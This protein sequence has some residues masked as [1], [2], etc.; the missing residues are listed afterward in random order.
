[1]CWTK[2]VCMSVCMRVRACVPGRLTACVSDR[3]S[4]RETENER[5]RAGERRRK[6]MQA[7]RPRG[8]SRLP[9]RTMTH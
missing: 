5:E 6:A 7:A 9:L 8:A 4:V 1:M 3:G 2:C